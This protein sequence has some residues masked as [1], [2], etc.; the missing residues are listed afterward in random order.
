MTTRSDSIRAWCARAWRCVLQTTQAMAG[1]DLTGQCTGGWPPQY[2]AARTERAPCATIAVPHAWWALDP[3]GW[4]RC[5]NWV[6]ETPAAVPEATQQR[7]S[8]RLPEFTPAE[9]ARL[10]ALRDQCQVDRDRFTTRELA[11]LQFVHWLHQSGRL[12][13]ICHVGYA[14]DEDVGVAHGAFVP[15]YH[16]R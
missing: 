15:V 8:E 10:R 1:C 16:P 9:Q 6:P 3:A 12:S 11:H 5:V 7:V 2:S 14:A 4:T 13:Q